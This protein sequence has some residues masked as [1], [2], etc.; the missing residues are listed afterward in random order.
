MRHRRVRPTSTTTEFAL[1]LIEEVMTDSQ[2]I[3][4]VV[5]TD[6]DPQPVVARSAWLAR[7]TNSKVVLLLCDADANTLA[8]SFILTSDAKDIAATIRRAQKELLDDLVRPLRQSG[9]TVS[10]EVLEER[11]IA[12]A[13]VQRALE[14]NPWVVVKGTQYHSQAKRAVFVDTD[15]QLIRSCP[16]ALWLVKPH[17]IAKRPVIVAAVDPTHKDDKSADLDQRIIEYAKDVA[18]KSAGEL[19]LLHAFEALTGIGAEAT[20]TFKPIR[21]PVNEISDNLKRKRRQKLD[22]LAEANS[23]DSVYTH[24]VEGNARDVLPFFARERKADLV[25]MGAIARWGLARKIIGNT[26]EKVLDDL[27]CDI[28]IV[29]LDDG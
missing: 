29:R 25:V 17:E 24:L 26:A 5:E 4:V 10:A 16:Y 7:L 9:V 11:P 1:L 14:L 12:D 13:V 27:P 22:A 23:I 15:W 28:L 2:T 20:R 3:L 6:I 8:Q 18:D 21:L 19:L